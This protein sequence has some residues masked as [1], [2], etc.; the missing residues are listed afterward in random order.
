VEDILAGGRDGRPGWR[1]R[2]LVAAAVVAAVSI[3]VVRHLPGGQHQV[4]GHVLPAVVVT[5]PLPRL[6]PGR[7]G[8]PGDVAWSRYRAFSGVRLPVSGL[9]PAWFWP[10]T[11]RAEPISGLPVT[12]AG[13]TFVRVIGGWALI[14]GTLARPACSACVWAPRS[15]YFLADG[16]AV[17]RPVGTAVLVAPA[18]GAGRLWLTS[19]RAGDDF[20]TAAGLAREV[21]AGG[22]PAGPAIRLPIG[23]AIAGAA[24]RGLLLTPAVPVEGSAAHVLWITGPGRAGGPYDSW[25]AVSAQQI[26]WMPRCARHCTVK[27]TDVLTGRVITARLPAGQVAISAAFSPD[28][29]YLAVQAGP[30]FV[31]TGTGAAT[32]LFVVALRTG[33]MEAV[34]G[35]RARG[36]ALVGFGWPGGAD[37]LVAELLSPATVLLSAW[38]PGTARPAVAALEPGPAVSG[39]VPG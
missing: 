15:V 38:Q 3:V 33:R 10:A 37:V 26:A 39:L 36:A 5:E 13:Y 21:A 24:G 12:G 16:A 2:L 27:V 17:A 18:A 11:G 19:Y 25:L 8:P 6:M 22:R 1:S 32:H 4:A 29:R 35:T 20:A 7:S 9:R 14:G 31:A 23:Y 30:D 34:P 28:G